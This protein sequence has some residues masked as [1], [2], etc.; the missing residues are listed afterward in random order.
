MESMQN[1][2]INKQTE[3]LITMDGELTD[4]ALKMD[5]MDEGVRTGFSCVDKDL[6]A[7]DGRVNRCRKDHDSVAEKLKVAEGKVKVLE[8]RSR[9]QCD[10]IEK[11]IMHVKSME[12]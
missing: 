11:L 1:C 5:I 8:E 10:M 4:M 6:E 7:L 9:T 2:T 3:T 12:D